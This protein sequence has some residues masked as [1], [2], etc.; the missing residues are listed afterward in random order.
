MPPLAAGF[1]APKGKRVQ[2]MTHQKLVFE[3]AGVESE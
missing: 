1:S 2:L 3:P